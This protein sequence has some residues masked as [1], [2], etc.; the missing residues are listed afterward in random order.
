MISTV[1]KFNNIKFGS[2]A[3]SNNRCLPDEAEKRYKQLPGQQ[4]LPGVCTVRRVLQRLQDTIRASLKWSRGV[5]FTIMLSR[6]HVGQVNRMM[7]P[8]RVPGTA[9][10]K[11]CDV[12]FGEF[13]FVVHVTGRCHAGTG[14]LRSKGFGVVTGGGLYVRSVT[15]SCNDQNRLSTVY[16]VR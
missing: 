10:C 1:P 7:H 2:L 8:F 3:V 13:P 9:E 15:F 16:L 4:P 5:L 12:I 11:V 14:D 6:A